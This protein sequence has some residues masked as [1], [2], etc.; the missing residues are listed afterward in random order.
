MATQHQFTRQITP[1]PGEYL[2]KLSERGKVIGELRITV[3][4]IVRQETSRE[5][6]SVSLRMDRPSKL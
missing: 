1:D 4:P 2:Y 6:F 5:R 3:S